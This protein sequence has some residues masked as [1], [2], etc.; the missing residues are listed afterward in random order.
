MKSALLFPGQAAQFVGM[1]TKL[2]ASSSKANDLLQQANEILDFDLGAIMASGPEEKL[3]ETKYTQPAV[4]V[5]SLMVYE[6]RKDEATPDAVAG[7]SLGELSACV[8]ADVFSFEEGLRLVQKRAE[9]M[10]LACEMA[11]STMAAV[12]GMS[13]EDVEAICDEIDGVVAANYNCPGQIVISGTFEGINK[14]VEVCKVRGARR[15]LQIPVG[16]AFHSPLMEPAQKAFAEAIRSVTM[17]NAQIPIYQNVN[18]LAVTNA[19]DI[20]KNLI[21]QVT[22]PVRWTKCIQSMIGDGI[23]QFIEVGGKGKVLLGMMRKISREVEA[24]GWL[25]E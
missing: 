20:R 7:H 22:S 21:D 24:T 6:S 9:A 8:V 13:D 17:N 10:Q 19:D 5:H 4:F 14:A 23:G 18:A 16:G 2:V 1:G 15:A 3:K 12:L 11:P 25:E